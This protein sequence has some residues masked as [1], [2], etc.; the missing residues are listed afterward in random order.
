MDSIVLQSNMGSMNFVPT[1]TSDNKNEVTHSTREET[2]HIEERKT[3]EDLSD[4]V[5]KKQSSIVSH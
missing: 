5:I 1:I 4:V 2:K 3:S